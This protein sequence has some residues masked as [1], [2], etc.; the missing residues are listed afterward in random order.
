VTL[1][2]IRRIEAMNPATARLSQVIA[3]C[4]F[5]F[6]LG[7][8]TFSLSGACAELH[9]PG[10]WAW[11]AAVGSIVG[12]GVSLTAAIRDTLRTSS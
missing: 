4:V 11:I 2:P 10:K 7:G 5:A 6:I 1:V 3:V 9:A 8:W 12:L